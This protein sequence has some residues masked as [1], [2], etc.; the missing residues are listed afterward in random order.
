MSC[1]VKDC[2]GVVGPHA[3]KPAA[4]VREISRLRAALVACVEA[5]AEVRGCKVCGEDYGRCLKCDRALDASLASAKEALG[6]E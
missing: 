3:H 1:G 4:Y 5:L 2:I 6:D